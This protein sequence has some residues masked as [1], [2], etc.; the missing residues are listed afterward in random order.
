MRYVDASKSHVHITGRERGR[1]GD[2]CHSSQQLI[3]HHLSLSLSLSLP[4]FCI[5]C[6]KSS[7]RAREPL[8]Q[9]A[10]CQRHQIDE[11]PV[12]ALVSCVCV[13]MCVYVCVHGDER[14]ANATI[15]LPLPG[16]LMTA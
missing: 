11:T 13:F 16:L 3:I 8:D 15:K 9:R 4:F 10:K 5:T 2:I 12:Q 6:V 1:K 14:V 7:A